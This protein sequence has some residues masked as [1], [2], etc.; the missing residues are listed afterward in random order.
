[1]NELLSK[2]VESIAAL[3]EDWHG[4]GT[5]NV[6]VLRAILSH[7]EKIGPIEHT[8]E[9]GSGKTTLLFSHLSPDHLVFSYD[10]AGSITRVKESSLCNNDRVTWVE[11]FTQ[12]T[13]PRYDFTHQFQI[14]LIDGPHGYPF[15]DL[16]YYYLYPHVATG[17]LLLL[18]DTQI[19]TI[20][21]MFDILKA[22]DAFRLLEVIDN[23]AYFQRTESPLFDPF[24]DGWWLQG[25]NAEAYRR[26]NGQ[27]SPPP[28][29]RMIRKAASSIGRLVP[30]PIKKLVRES[31][32]AALQDG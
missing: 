9:T 1:M 26:M 29:R 6:N 17:G 28:P 12:R 31:L 5:V 3:P 21:R 19:P 13:I 23:M 32:K 11:G 18:D 27:S 2:H 15:P 8:V 24:G 16:E 4:C 20:G 30:K 25:Y 7:A 22:D 14:V 10:H